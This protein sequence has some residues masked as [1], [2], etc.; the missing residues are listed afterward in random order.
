MD[1][2]LHDTPA[3]RPPTHT[4]LLPSK[5]QQPA[6][7]TTAMDEGLMTWLNFTRL[8]RLLARLCATACQT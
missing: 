3:L 7:R 6:S 1:E 5:A 4:L 8:L 2:G